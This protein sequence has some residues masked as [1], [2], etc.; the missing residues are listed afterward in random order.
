MVAL[1]EIALITKL[2]LIL[3]DYFDFPVR[4]W[5]VCTDCNGYFGC[6]IAEIAINPCGTLLSKFIVLLCITVKVDFRII[7]AMIVVLNVMSII[8][9]VAAKK[10]RYFKLLT[11][12]VLNHWFSANLRQHSI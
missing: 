7:M 3:F 11:F 5:N 2:N 4:S 10:K 9:T 6:A 8:A 1:V 12:W